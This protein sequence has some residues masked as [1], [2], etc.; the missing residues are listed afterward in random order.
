MIFQ[1]IKVETTVIPHFCVILTAKFI[2]G[3]NLVICRH[4][5]RQKVNFK[6]KRTILRSSK[7]KYDFYQIKLETSVIP[8]FHVILTA[9]SISGYFLVI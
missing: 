4:P 8:H 1:Q 3:T 9:K 5:Q 7:Q 2:S 6:V